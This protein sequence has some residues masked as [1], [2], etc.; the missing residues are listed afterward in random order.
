[1]D[2]VLAFKSRESVETG[3]R[4]RLDIICFGSSCRTK[5]GRNSER[6][7]FERH[8]PNRRSCPRFSRFKESKRNL[9]PIKII[10]LPLANGQCPQTIKHLFN[11][12]LKI[13]KHFKSRYA[14]YI[15]HMHKNRISASNFNTS[16]FYLKQ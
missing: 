10:E 2:S 12:S 8:M 9:L 7:T 4:L 3:I 11:N 14:F 6:K 5:R 16:L 15:C 1:M 13:H